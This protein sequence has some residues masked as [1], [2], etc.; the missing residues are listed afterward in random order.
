MASADIKAIAETIRN[1]T[2]SGGSPLDVIRELAGHLATLATH[3]ADAIDQLEQ[4]GSALTAPRPNNADRRPAYLVSG[5]RINGGVEIRGKMATTRGQAM[6]LEFHDQQSYVTSI[7]HST[8]SNLPLNLIGSTVTVTGTFVLG[9]P[10]PVAS[11]GTGT[12]TG[13]ITGTTDLTFTAGGSNKS[14]TLVSS[15]TGSVILK[16]GT[17]STTAVIVKDAGGTAIATVDSTN[18]QVLVGGA[19]AISTTTVAAPAGPLDVSASNSTAGPQA[20]AAAFFRNVDTTANNG[21]TLAFTTKNG[22]AAV[23]QPCWI[24]ALFTDHTA[25]SVKGELAFYTANNSD[26]PTER[27][28]ISKEGNLGVNTTSQFGSGAGVVGIANAAT[29]PSTNPTGGGVLYCDSGALK[30]RGSGGTVTTIAPA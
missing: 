2:A 20:A 11:G 17:D 29:N 4:Q 7:D 24:H 28:R 6:D 26:L 22:S 23:V 8:G 27:L 21:W 3:A 16:P 10:L 30:F 18:K 5:D 9:S 25:G 13:S 12:A 14:V 15:G 19:V 1:L